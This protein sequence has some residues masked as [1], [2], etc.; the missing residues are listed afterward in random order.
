[1]TVRI[2]KDNHG[3][4]VI[5]SEVGGKA[6]PLPA[7]HIL[8]RLSDGHIFIT[9]AGLPGL[10]PLRPHEPEMVKHWLREKGAEIAP[11]VFAGDTP[12][13]G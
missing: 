7:E 5:W 11:N 2:E 8:V 1:M 6:V 3:R 12:P 13:D 4:D 10:N 9:S